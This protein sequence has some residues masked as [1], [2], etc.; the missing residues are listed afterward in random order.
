MLCKAV[1]AELLE[2]AEER[3]AIFEYEAGMTRKR[4]EKMAAERILRREGLLGPE[5]TELFDDRSN[6]G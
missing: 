3:A 6:Q 2:E 1:P 5:Q 4:A